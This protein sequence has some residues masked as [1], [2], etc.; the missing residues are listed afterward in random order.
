MFLLS[1]LVS[2][3]LPKDKAALK[4]QQVDFV[5][6]KIA[7][8]SREFPS[9]LVEWQFRHAL[10]SFLLSLNTCTHNSVKTGLIF[11]LFISAKNLF[12]LYKFCYIEHTVYLRSI[13]AILW[14][15]P[16]FVPLL[17]LKEE[18]LGSL[19]S[20]TVNFCWVVKDIFACFLKV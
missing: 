3:I 13:L 7:C 4:E 19:K 16:L 11:M 9:I 14:G 2:F 5:C 17:N 10:N 8:L 1:F 20:V 15:F 6:C 12:C 18:T